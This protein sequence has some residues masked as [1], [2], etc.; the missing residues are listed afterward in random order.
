MSLYTKTHVTAM[1]TENLGLGGLQSEGGGHNDEDRGGHVFAKH[2][3][4][5]T[6]DF[7]IRLVLVLGMKHMI[8]MNQVYS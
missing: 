4:K 5:P 7:L 8:C 6:K 3:R 1:R 2:I